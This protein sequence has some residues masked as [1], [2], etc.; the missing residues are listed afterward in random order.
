MIANNQAGIFFHELVKQYPLSDIIILSE[1]GYVIGNHRK[2]GILKGRE[3]R[4]GLVEEIAGEDGKNYFKFRIVLSESVEM[5]MLIGKG[6]RRPEVVLRN[7]LLLKRRYFAGENE[8]AFSSGS[9]SEK[10]RF[11]MN[12]LMSKYDADNERIIYR[13]ADELKI[14]LSIARVAV[15]LDFAELKDGGRRRDSS[16]VAGLIDYLK[17][18]RIVREDVLIYTENSSELILL[19]AVD[20]THSVKSQL[21]PWLKTLAKDATN[22]LKGEVSISVGSIATKPGGY[23]ESLRIARLLSQVGGTPPGNTDAGDTSLRN[24]DADQAAGTSNMRFVSDNIIP[25]VLE[26]IPAKT[27]DHYFES[28]ARIIEKHPELLET[29][30]ALISSGMN[31]SQAA[32][33]NHMHRNTMLLRTHQLRDLL[34]LDPIHREGDSLTMQF[35]YHYT[36]R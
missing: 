26:H 7:L 33:A 24:T 20:T 22:Y 27:L 32:R 31:I 4:G 19:A 15:L 9:Y 30:A 13:L 5:T 14:D 11:L 25:L 21:T 29:M 36:K 3:S 2:L 34:A 1:D 28:R 10:Q 18:N 23:R 12:Q 35:L 16:T 6:K 8:S 17:T